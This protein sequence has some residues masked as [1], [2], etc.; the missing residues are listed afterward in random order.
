MNIDISLEGKKLY[1]GRSV[2]LL[3][4]SIFFYYAGTD[5]ATESGV[6]IVLNHR[7]VETGFGTKNDYMV[8]LK[9]YMKKARSL[10]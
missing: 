8:Y 4:Y 5:N 2:T 1:F 6:D 7:L 9:D 10:L 3:S